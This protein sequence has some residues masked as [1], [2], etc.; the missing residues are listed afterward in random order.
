MAEYEWIIVMVMLQ[1][2]AANT[3]LGLAKALGKCLTEVILFSP[4]LMSFI[5]MPCRAWSAYPHMRDEETQ[6]ER[7][8]NMG[9]KAS[10]GTW[11]FLI[12]EPIHLTILGCP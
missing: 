11:L 9:G 4:H 12:P 2:I 8:G 1:I 6:A 3:Y 10:L 5:I 7:Q